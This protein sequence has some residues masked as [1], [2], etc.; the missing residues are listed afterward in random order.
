[1]WNRNNLP[2]GLAIGILL[3]LLSFIIFYFTLGQLEST[4]MATNF[5]ERTLAIIAMCMNIIPFN[6]YQKRRFT[7]SMRGLSIATIIYAIIWL[8]YYGNQ[9]LN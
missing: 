7:Q 1:M 3:P 5:R 6:I 4:G 2:I 9:I 8:I